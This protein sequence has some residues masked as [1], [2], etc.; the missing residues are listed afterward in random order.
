M[1]HASTLPF[2]FQNLVTSIVPA[3]IG[4]FVLQLIIKFKKS[5]KVFVEQTVQ[6]SFLVRPH[7]VFQCSVCAWNRSREEIFFT[8]AM[9]NM[10]TF[11]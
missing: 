11:T 10:F 8:S 4:Q 2:P 5:L 1:A 7:D 9:D 3:K 6:S